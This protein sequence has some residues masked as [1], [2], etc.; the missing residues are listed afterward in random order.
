M[1]SSKQPTAP[2]TLAAEP[3]ELEA[4]ANAADKPAVPTFSFPFNPSAFAQAKKDNP[5]FSFPFNPSAFAQAKKD[6]QPWYQKSGKGGHDK[7]PGA[8]P[9]GTRKTM[10]KR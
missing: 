9:H 1:T 10:G 5:A 2:E 8:P 4:T 7:T 3:A 6:N